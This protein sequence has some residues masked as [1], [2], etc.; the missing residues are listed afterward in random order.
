M[1]ERIVLIKVKDEYCTDAAREE[2][3]AH[4]LAALEGLPGLGSVHVG[5]P[6][7]EASGKSWDLSIVLHFDSLRAAEQ[8]RTNP[9]HRSYVDDYLR[10]RMEVIKAWNFR[11]PSVV[12]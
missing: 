9:E 11:R 4:T 10:P 7:D 5:V 6:A 12:G 3:A 8:F 1:I 2:T